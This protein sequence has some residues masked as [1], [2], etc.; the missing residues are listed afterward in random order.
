MLGARPTEGMELGT[1]LAVLTFGL[2]LVLVVLVGFD[3]PRRLH[4]RTDPTAGT[5]HLTT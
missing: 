5:D 4:R 1:A 3:V 2:S